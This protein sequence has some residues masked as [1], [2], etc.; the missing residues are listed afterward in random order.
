[1]SEILRFSEPCDKILP[2]YKKALDEM[3]KLKK[4]ASNPHFKSKYA[5]LASVTETIDDPLST[6]G[7]FHLEGG[8][9]VFQDGEWQAVL[10]ARIIHAASGQW[11][12]NTCALPLTKADAQG[13]GS[14]FTY[15][16]RYALQGLCGLAPEDDDGNKASE[17]PQAR[18]AAAAPPQK[19]DDARAG[20]FAALCEKLPPGDAE[21]ILQKVQAQFANPPT[22]RIADLHDGEESREAYKALLRAEKALSVA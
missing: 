22:G 4:N 12:E 10:V 11:V 1:M 5:D 7:L 17:R 13:G 15:A 14:A 18:P 19:I 8:S 6:N 16:R 9:C 21:I 2:A 20:L 3:G